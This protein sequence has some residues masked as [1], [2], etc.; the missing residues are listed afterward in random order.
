MGIAEELKEICE[1][2]QRPNLEGRA[3]VML[4]TP[5]EKN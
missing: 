4:L 2:E 3:M 5:A 1:I